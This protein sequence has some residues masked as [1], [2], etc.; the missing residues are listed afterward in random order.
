[1][2]IPT[3]QGSFY[4]HSHNYHILTGPVTM[5][6]LTLLVLLTFGTVGTF[7]FLNYWTLTSYSGS[8]FPT[9]W[10]S[11]GTLISLCAETSQAFQCKMLT[12]CQTH[13]IQSSHPICCMCWPPRW[14]TSTALNSGLISRAISVIAISV[15]I[16]NCLLKSFKRK[17]LFLTTCTTTRPPYVSPFKNGHSLLY[18]FFQTKIWDTSLSLFLSSKIES[19]AILRNSTLEINPKSNHSSLSPHLSVQSRSQ[20]VLP[21]PPC[22]L[23]GLTASIFTIWALLAM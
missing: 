19:I 5:A 12:V 11:L 7:S 22:L 18:H 3:L 16:S 21:G 6:A 20:P 17:C 14:I 23:S 15:I 2:L 8:L 4:S 13:P 10:L 9:H 1:M